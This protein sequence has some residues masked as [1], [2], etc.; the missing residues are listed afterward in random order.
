MFEEKWNHVP[1]RAP[2]HK[3]EIALPEILF[4]TTFP[5]RECGI[6][7]YSQD[8]VFALKNQ[9]SKSFYISICA[10][11]TETEKPTYIQKPKYILNTDCK[12]SY[13]TIKTK[14]NQNK[15][16]NL[17][18]IQHEFGL[19]SKNEPTFVDFY[20]NINKPIVFV[21]HTV[22]PHPTAAFIKKVRNMAKSAA[23]IIVMTQNAAHILNSEYE[24]PMHKIHVIANG[25]HLTKPLNKELLKEKYFFEGK[26][27]LST[28]GLLSPNKGIEVTLNALPSIIK[29]FPYVL[30]LILGKT[31]PAIKKQDG[32]QYRMQLEAKVKALQIKN[33]VLFVNEYLPLPILLEYLQLTDI[34]LFTST[35][36]NQAVSGTFAYALGAGCPIVSTPIPHAKELLTK[37]TGLFFDFEDSDKLASAAIRLL[38][39]TNLAKKISL[40]ALHKMAPTAWENSAIF[41]A[42]L[43]WELMKK[44]E[45]IIYQIPPL[46]LNHI[47]NMTTDFGMIQFANISNPDLNSGYTIDDN[48]RALIATCQLFERTKDTKL[49]PF[50]DIYLN[51]IKCC[52]QDNGKFINYMDIHKQIT[53]QNKR[54]NLEDSNGRAIWALGYIVS[55][56]DL[57]PSHC[58][59]EAD[60]LLQK[61]LPQI[62]KIHSKRAMAFIIKGLYFQNREENLYLIKIFADRLVQMYL[63]EST[64]DWFWYEDCLTYGN[65]VL[66]EALLCAYFSLQDP[67]YKIIAETSFDFLLSK[68][69][70]QNQIHVISNKGWLLKNKKARKTLGGEQPIDVAYTIMALEKFHTTFPKKGYKEKAILAFNWF[71][72]ENHLNQIIY[73]PCTGGCYDGI[74][75]K[76]VNLNQGAESTLSYLMAK[77]AIDRINSSEY[78]SNATKKVIVEKMEEFS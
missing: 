21:F 40:N 20:K 39:K 41:H 48:A 2:A 49:L 5:S 23:A 7:T 12:E 16:L 28:F 42:K 9:F 4:I 51:Y 69:F 68:I 1:F 6:A 58:S 53:V 55:I 61:V 27:I 36:P 72:G 59:Q 35:D 56:K 29:Y 38:K 67:H 43:F 26:R 14:I 34:Y 45:K 18:V 52:L 70:K 74:E 30:F 11:E 65:S 22:L 13:A 44:D 64:K 73:N 63:H 8:L 10:L 25:T 50:I 66:P 75:S 60:L 54:E 31:H 76:N 78:K 15:D 71:L 57:L 32:E 24:I 33:H 19:F 47:Q 62:E 3:R 77:L 46:N 37:N 17:V